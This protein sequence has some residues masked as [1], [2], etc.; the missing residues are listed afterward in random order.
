MENLPKGILVDDSGDGNGDVYWIS[1]T[2]YVRRLVS[3]M[4]AVVP[5]LDSGNDLLFEIA[6]GGGYVYGA[7]ESPEQ[8]VIAWNLADIMNPAQLEAPQLARGVAA[9][10][11]HVYWLS[12][13]ADTIMKAPAGMGGTSLIT[14]ETNLRDIIVE[15]AALYWLAGDTIRTA[16]TSGPP[17]SDLSSWMGAISLAA[18][19]TVLCVY[20]GPSKDVHCMSTAGASLADFSGVNGDVKA[21]DVADN[22]LYWTE[23]T[24]EVMRAQISPAG[25]PEALYDATQSAESIAVHA[26]GSKHRIYWTDAANRVMKLIRWDSD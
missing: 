1:G 13:N 24:G 4:G 21:I 16:S 6:A 25:T 20:Y 23:S 26:D 17:A 10:A 9:D 3:G 2:R 15:D 8:K 19:D 22:Y 5:L 18:Y 7:S 14:G 11:T 12:G